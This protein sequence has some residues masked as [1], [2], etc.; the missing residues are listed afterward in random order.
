MPNLLRLCARSRAP[1]PN[2]RDVV[3]ATTEEETAGV[4]NDYDNDEDGHDDADDKADNAAIAAEGEDNER[5]CHQSYKQQSTVQAGGGNN[6]E[7][8]K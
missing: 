1:S 4:S 2:S 8:D 3:V 5:R 7:E 6:V